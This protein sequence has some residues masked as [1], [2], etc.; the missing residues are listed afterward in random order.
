[1]L[2]LGRSCARAGR[3]CEAFQALVIGLYFSP[4][5]DLLH[6][7]LLG[8]L[9]DASR[10]KRAR[11]ELGL[12]GN[13]GAPYRR[14]V[15][16]MLEVREY[17][18]AGQDLERYAELA[19]DDAPKQLRDT[20]AT[21]R[22]LNQR[23]ERLLQLQN[24]Q[25]YR[26][27]TAFRVYMNAAL[28]FEKYYPLFQGTIVKGLLAMLERRSPGHPFVG[29]L[30][31]RWKA[32]HRDKAEAI[33]E[34]ETLVTRHP[35]FIPALTQLVRYYLDEG[36]REDAAPYLCRILSLYPG[37]YNWMYYE[38]VELVPRPGSGGALLRDAFGDIGGQRVIQD[39]N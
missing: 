36:R 31:V 22:G 39:G 3:F 35:D 26:E 24:D 16:V 14:M 23:E 20:L 2:A 33:Q 15:E 29:L 17:E 25:V 19:P 1:M 5:S 7:M 6:D 21:A 4:R 30:R 11:F 34:A 38:K 32:R 10:D 12:A 37:H 8:V 27:D 13:R 9:Q 18:L 28:F